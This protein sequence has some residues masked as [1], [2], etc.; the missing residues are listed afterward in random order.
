MGYGGPHA[1]FFAT[2]DAYKRFLPG[3]DHRRLQGPRRP[4]RAPDGAADPRAAHPPRQGDEQRLH[5]PGA[6]GR[7]GEHVRGLP[8]PRRAPPHRRAGARPRGGAGERAAPA[9]LP[10]GARLVLRHDL[11]RGARVGAAPAARRG[12]GADDQLPAAAARPGSASRWTR[13][14][15]LGDL[16]DLIAVFSLNEA[17]PFMLEDIGRQADRAIP[18]G[19]GA[20]APATWR[21]R[22]SICTTPR[23]RCCA[24]SSGSRRATSRSPAR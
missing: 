7:D 13:P 18:R 24:T 10:G 23:P 4:A 9:A 11:R 22:S 5:R 14:S 6:A 1:A 2:R 19:A 15:T 3:P 17:L 21:T 12:A 8:R 20:R 16:A